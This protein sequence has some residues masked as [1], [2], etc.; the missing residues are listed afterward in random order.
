M[1]AEFNCDL[2][3]PSSPFPHFW[4]HTIGSG[5]ATLTLRADW[6]KQ[7]TRCHTEL[8]FKRVRF[9]GILS[10]DMGTLMCETEQLVYS[11]FNA[12]QVCDFLMSI[13]MVPFIE[14]SFMP[15]TLSS[16][17]DTVFHYRGNITPPRD[18][19]AWQTL[20]HHLVQHWVD[21][22]GIENMGDWF[23]EVWNEPNLTAFW[24]GSQQDY[25]KLYQYT[26]NAVKGV[27]PQLK[28]G[29]PATA[30]N[31]WVPEF[32]AF[33]EKNNVPYDFIST[34]HYPTDAF[35][36]P[37]DDTIAQLAASRRSVLREQVATT[38]QNA[39]DVP[40]YYTEWS[41]SSNPFDELH[42]MP[43]AAA[44]I[45]KTIMEAREYVQGYSY[46]TFTDIFEE[47]Y[48]SSTPFHGGFG[49]MNIYGVPKPAYRAYELLHRLGQDILPV[50]GQH[51]TVDVWVV[52]Q[53][54]IVHVLLTNSALPRHAVNAET[55][56]I[57]VSNIG[58]V[59][60]VYVERV[61]DTHANATAAWAQMGKPSSLSVQQV[62]AL[63]AASNLIKETV[64]YTLQN[65]TASLQIQLLPQATA[66]ITIET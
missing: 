22:Y 53:P 46:W 44:F 21:R 37:G 45:T 56:T 20:I 41:T 58:Q 62:Q 17:N 25:F 13:G 12:D 11:F 55:V 24:T 36:Q 27:N 30:E 15:T 50:Q 42:D 4:E 38:R 18:Y 7:L 14:F 39:G 19:G 63:E 23:F 16:G 35:G 9:H 10:D 2:K 32:R 6:Q 28:V 57:T 52:T 1:P 40:V 66:L 26:A 61:D 43:Y 60:N 29:G 59:K 47:N 34:H 54:G 48:F 49:L 51:A 3:S 65:N 31:A 64:S 8:G 33:C 5:H